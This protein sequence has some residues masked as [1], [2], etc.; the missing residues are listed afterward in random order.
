MKTELIEKYKF[1]LKTSSDQ[2]LKMPDACGAS[3][4]EW[5]EA[6][7]RFYTS[8]KIRKQLLETSIPIQDNFCFKN[9]YRIS[10]AFVKRL[11]F[12]EGFSYKKNTDTCL[13]HA[14]NVCKN[15]RVVDYS[16]LS[17]TTNWQD[18]YIGVM[19]PLSFAR[20]IYFKKED[21]K[22]SQYSLLVPYYLY[23]TENSDY[24]QYAEL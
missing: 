2:E 4:W 23:K 7:S 5:F 1:Q 22:H 15:D 16:L 11:Y 18:V 17:K 6:K 21:Y 3:F 19:I 10:K 9:T 12:S 24:L 20:M 14:F 13:R 8:E